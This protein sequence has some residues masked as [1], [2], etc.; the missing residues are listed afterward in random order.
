MNVNGSFRRVFSNFPSLTIRPTSTKRHSLNARY[1]LKRKSRLLFEVVSLFSLKMLTVVLRS[2]NLLQYSST[3]RWNTA[4]TR[5]RVIFSWLIVCNK[6]QVLSN[7]V[8]IFEV[9]SVDNLQEIRKAF[10]ASNNC[11]PYWKILCK[12]IRKLNE[13]SWDVRIGLIKRQV[14]HLSVVLYYDNFLSYFSV[15][16]KNKYLI[17]LLFYLYS[18]SFF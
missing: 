10:D 15:E 7:F 12:Y 17:L 5:S 3:L 14:L 4:E 13:K 9:S 1:F 6:R 11:F 16:I 18:D 2:C 8:C